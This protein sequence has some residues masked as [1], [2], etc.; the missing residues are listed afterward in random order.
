MSM[1]RFF[2]SKSRYNE[3][4]GE[5]IPTKKMI[6]DWND[7]VGLFLSVSP[8]D[9]QFDYQLD[10]PLRVSKQ[11]PMREPLAIYVLIYFLGHLVRYY[12]PDVL[13]ALL[14]RLRCMDNRALHAV[15]SRYIAALFEKSYSRQK[16]RICFALTRRWGAVTGHARGRPSRSSLSS[17]T[18]I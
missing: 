18:S 7:A 9:E 15:S 14:G 6:K 10:F 4:E 16:L 1:F 17:P 5:I 2:E 3:I 8:Y 13:E 11:S 12:H